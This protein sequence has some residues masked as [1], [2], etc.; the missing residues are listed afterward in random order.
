[1]LPPESMLPYYEGKSLRQRFAL[2]IGK[3]SAAA[4]GYATRELRRTLDTR[5]VG[6][7]CESEPGARAS[8]YST[9]IHSD[10]Q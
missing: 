2:H 1:M 10:A 7:T 8:R 4:N 6:P 3:C 9:I 5:L